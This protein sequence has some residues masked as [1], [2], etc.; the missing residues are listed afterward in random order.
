MTGV[1]RLCGCTDTTPCV[2]ELEQNFGEIITKPCWWEADDLCSGCSMC[3][4][5][6]QEANDEEQPT[7]FYDAQGRPID[8]RG[9]P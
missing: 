5:E 9:R 6:E 3:E 1:C 8:L 7:L 4:Q 2:L